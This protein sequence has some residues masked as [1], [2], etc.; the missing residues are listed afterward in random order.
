MEEYYLYQTYI[1]MKPLE[2]WLL[3]VL[4]RHVI[5]V[6]SLIDYLLGPQSYENKNLDV[7]V[8]HNHWLSWILLQPW[9]KDTH[10]DKM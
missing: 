7:I 3:N 10:I 6:S 1:V 4:L 2:L 9:Y 5:G 8:S